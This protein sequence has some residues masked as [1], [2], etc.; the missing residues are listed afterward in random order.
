MNYEEY[1]WKGI[2]LIFISI[3]C[4]IIGISPL[5]GVKPFV[6]LGAVLSFYGIYWTSK[7][8]EVKRLMKYNNLFKENR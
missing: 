7:Y 6:F 8:I 1:R 2:F 3:I 5:V 4:V